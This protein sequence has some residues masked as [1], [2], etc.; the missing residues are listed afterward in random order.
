[1]LP[2]ALEVLLIIL[3]V[4]ITLGVAF[5]YRNHQLLGQILDEL[6]ARPQRVT[7][8]DDAGGVAL[9]PR[10]APTPT[11]GS[12]TA[13]TQPQIAPAPTNPTAAP[14]VARTPSP[15]PDKPKLPDTTASTPAPPQPVKPTPA[16]I[17]P[18]TTPDSPEWDQAAVTMTQFA[19]NLLN[20]K[21]DAVVKQFDSHMASN[22]PKAQLAAVMDPIRK[23]NGDFAQITE[24]ALKQKLSGGMNVFD[25]NVQFTSGHELHLTVTLDDK[26]RIAGLMMN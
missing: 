22:L 24:H 6:R 15:T 20:G 3:L 18:T 17:A 25:V 12:D 7:L 1:M 23:Q 13:P 21:Y 2:R 5:Q 9:K 14:D 16:P 26:Q 4:V 10:P 8:T 19:Q 11:P